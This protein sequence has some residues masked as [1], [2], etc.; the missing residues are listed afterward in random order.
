MLFSCSSL[1]VHREHCWGGQNYMGK[2]MGQ[3]YLPLVM[4]FDITVL[5]VPKLQKT[6]PRKVNYLPHFAEA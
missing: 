1:F 5:E 4:K 3:Q 6:I 2:N